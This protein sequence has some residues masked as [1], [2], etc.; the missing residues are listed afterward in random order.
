[1]ARRQKKSWSDLTPGQRAL[2]LGAAG[3]Q[4]GLLVAALA[5]IRRRPPDQV[6]G[7]KAIWVAV[8]FINFV[9]PLA[10]FRFGRRR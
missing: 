4:V 10:Y 6:R 9:G 8:S 3:L 5:D 2:A 1:M 7:S